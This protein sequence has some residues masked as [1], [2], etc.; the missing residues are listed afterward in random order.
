MVD[1]VAV[2]NGQERERVTRSFFPFVG[3]FIDSISD[4]GNNAAGFSM[5]AVALLICYEAAARYIFSSPTVWIMSVSLFAFMWFPFLSASYG[6]KTEKHITCDVFIVLLPERSRECILVLTEL[7]SL[8]FI[9]SLGYFGYL[10]CHE[11]YQFQ[12]TSVGLVRYPLWVLRIIIPASMLVCLLQTVRNVLVRIN[13][14]RV[15]TAGTDSRFDHPAIFGVIYIALFAIG[16]GIFYHSPSIAILYMALVLL[17]S[18]V[19]VGFGL[20]VVGIIAL[21]AIHGGIAGLNTVPI[22]AENTVHNFVLLAIPLFTLGGVILSKSGLA[23]EIYDTADKWLGWL[24]GGLAA[25]TCITGGILAAMIGSST[26]VTAIIALVAMEP[27]LRAGYRKRLVIGTV[28]GTSLGLIIPPSIGFIVYGYLTDTSVGSLFLAGFVPGSMLVLMFSLYVVFFSWH[29]GSGHVSRYTWKE[30]FLSLFKSI[31]VLLGPVFVLGS[32]YTGL[33]TP[34]EAGAVL[35]IYSLLCTI[36]YRRMD[37]STFVKCLQ[38]SSII[39]TMILIIM[40][41]ALTMSHTITLLQVPSRLTEYIIS[42][43]FSNIVLILILF[44]LYLVLGMFLDGGSMT[45]LTIPILA[46]MFPALGIDTI[47]FGVVLMMLVEVALLTPPVGLNLFTVKGIVN[48]PLSLIIKG[49]APFT[50][51]ILLAAVLVMLFPDL[52]LWLP[53]HMR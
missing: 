15:R 41:G 35:V 19:P 46:P 45:I 22:V 30:R 37:F 33:C 31:V 27:M 18:G 53:N 6:I 14:L 16:I 26:A 50:V 4:A 43:G 3:R 42:S 7:T 25:A 36:I 52:A 40:M 47:V 1:E 48:E 13:R 9:L 49:T 5:L 39:A 21:I 51:L 17:L 23:Q 32:I 24:P 34:T 10:Y 29:T 2:S 8:I 28:T 44:L 11:A 20:G 12:E 38:Q